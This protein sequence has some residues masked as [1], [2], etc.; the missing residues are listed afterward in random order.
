MSETKIKSVNC[1][2]IKPSFGNARVA[3]LEETTDLLRGIDLD[4]IKAG[5]I[6][7]DTLEKIKDYVNGIQVDEKS[8]VQGPLKT[9]A[10][11]VLTIGTGMLVAKGTANKFFYMLK[12]KPFVQRAFRKMGVKLARLARNIAGKAELNKTAG[13]ARKYFFQALDVLSKK[14]ASYAKKGTTTLPAQAEKLTKAAINTAGV[15]TGF[16][17]TGAAL[18]VDNDENGRS[19]I[20]EG[21][22]KQ[23]KQTQKAV[24]DFAQVILDA[25]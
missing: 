4:K 18:S 2:P 21:K 11:S 8:K 22:N 16:A 23:D 6:E 1:A 5:Q 7:E 19:D 9:L 25:V 14:V 17:T 10:L 3:R 13:A 12:D 15:I 24:L 20:I